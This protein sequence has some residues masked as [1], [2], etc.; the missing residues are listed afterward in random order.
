MKKNS[1]NSKIIVDVYVSWMVCFFLLK[2]VV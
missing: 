2:I 1:F